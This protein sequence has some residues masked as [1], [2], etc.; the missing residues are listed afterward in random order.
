MILNNSSISV[1]WTPDDFFQ[2]KK[3]CRTRLISCFASAETVLFF[4]HLRYFRFV[5]ARLVKG[6]VQVNGLT[7][8]S[9][10]QFGHASHTVCQWELSPA[11][12]EETT[13]RRDFGGKPS[14]WRGRRMLSWKIRNFIA[15]AEPDQKTAFSAFLGYPS[16]I[17]RTTY[18]K[19][20]YPNQ[21]YRWK[22][23]TLKMCLLLVWRV[24][25]QAFGR[26]I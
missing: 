7:G 16:T 4:T 2:I 6:K 5:R 25:D 26:Y 22:A 11:G 15:L 13:D 12:K 20:F 14:K 24:S 10:G 3:I 17:L 18:R 9:R 19:Q 23:E 1:H 21:W 8:G